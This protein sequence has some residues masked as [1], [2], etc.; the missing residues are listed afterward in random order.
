MVFIRL[1][2]SW[3]RDGISELTTAHNYGGLWV[4]CIRHTQAKIVESYLS[5]VQK[6]DE[7]AR[8][9]RSGVYHVPIPHGDCR[10]CVADLEAEV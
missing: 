4:L 8:A 6:L 7:Y 9:S 10:W 1:I 2:T 3:N 5:Q